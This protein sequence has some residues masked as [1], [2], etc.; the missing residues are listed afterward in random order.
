MAGILKTS[1]LL[2]SPGSGDSEGRLD[3]GEGAGINSGFLRII[4]CFLN[5]VWEPVLEKYG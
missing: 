1:P 5:L 2:R 3:D 4:K